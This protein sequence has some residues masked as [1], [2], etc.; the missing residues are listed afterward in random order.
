MAQA[1]R[2]AREPAL[3]HKRK[4]RR[5][6]AV[7][8]RKPAGVSCGT[9]APARRQSQDGGRSAR[10]CDQRYSG[11][12]NIGQALGRFVAGKLGRIDPACIIE[13]VVEDRLAPEPPRGKTHDD[14]MTFD[15]AFLVTRDRFAV[16]RE[17]NRLDVDLR[18]LAHLANDCV[19]K[20]LAGL[21]ATAWQS[22]KVERWLTRAPD[23][24]H[25]TISDDGCA[26][27]QDG[28]LRIGS[29]VS[30]ARYRFIS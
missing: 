12:D 23:D 17:R 24:Q 7:F 29:L 5:W 26:H 20:P 11:R 16:P 14:K 28:T 27:R 25:L 30:H 2:F 8:S 6:R 18:F 3:R 10:G 22:I 21:N 9:Y 13:F 4:S 19:S 1:R 15:A